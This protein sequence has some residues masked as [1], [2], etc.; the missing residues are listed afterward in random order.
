MRIACTWKKKNMMIGDPF[1]RW[2]HWRHSKSRWRFK[3]I[4]FLKLSLGKLYYQ[5]DQWL[6]SWNCLKAQ[7]I[8]QTPAKHPHKLKQSDY[9]YCNI[10]GGPCLEYGRPGEALC[11]E[12]T[13]NFLRTWSTRFWTSS[14]R[15]GR[16]HYNGHILGLRVF[17]PLHPLPHTSLSSLSSTLRQTHS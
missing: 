7:K 8:T 15:P 5:G 2:K 11:L 14:S 4:L 3:F 12:F 10:P 6:M 1:L 16:Q 17:I 13:Q 9:G